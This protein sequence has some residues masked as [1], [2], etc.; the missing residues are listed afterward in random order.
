ML[1]AVNNNNVM[2]FYYGY[3]LLW[4]GMLLF[5]AKCNNII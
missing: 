3:R 5:D 4:L 2:T 1:L